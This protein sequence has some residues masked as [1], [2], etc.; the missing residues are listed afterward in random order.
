MDI[1]S[2]GQIK[3]PTPGTPVALTADPTIKVNAIVVS[4]VPGG[5]G[6]TFL[7]LQNAIN[8]VFNKA[9]GAGVVKSFLPAGPSGF[10]NTHTVQAAENSNVLV[11]ADYRVDA[12]T[13]NDG[14][15]AYGIRV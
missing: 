14:L 4:Q 10:L 1:I 2:F 13:A 6:V 5:V 3:V 12:N 9:T 7:G 15:Y 11:A 8:P